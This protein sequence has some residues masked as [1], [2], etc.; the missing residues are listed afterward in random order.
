MC[1]SKV[2]ALLL[3]YRHPEKRKCIVIAHISL[4][5]SPKYLQ[6]DHKQ[7]ESDNIKKACLGFLEIP[8]DQRAFFQNVVLSSLWLPSIGESSSNLINKS[9]R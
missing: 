1:V 9:A 8:L 4:L 7:W 6:Y 2:K 5:D 3:R